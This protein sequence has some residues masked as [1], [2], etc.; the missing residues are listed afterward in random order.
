MG[1]YV[2]TSV[3]ISHSVTDLILSIQLKDKMCL[4]N[5]ECGGVIQASTVFD[6]YYTIDESGQ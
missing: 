5:G 4:L 3:N 2:V 6:S 1:V